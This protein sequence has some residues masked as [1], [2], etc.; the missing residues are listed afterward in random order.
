MVYYCL[1]PHFIVGGHTQITY[2]DFGA[3]S[4]TLFLQR[5]FFYK[6]AVFLSSVFWK[7]SHRL[8]S[9]LYKEPLL[10]HGNNHSENL[11]F[12]KNIISSILVHIP[13]INW[14]YCRSE[15]IDLRHWG[16]FCRTL[17]VQFSRLTSSTPT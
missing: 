7:I 16:K 5:N 3:L 12:H 2:T 6:I 4:N 1:P 9:I 11:N 15:N 10:S 17:R 13:L 8:I 14:S